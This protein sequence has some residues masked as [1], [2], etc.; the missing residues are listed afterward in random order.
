MTWQRQSPIVER[1]T[2][3]QL[4]R[5]LA[6]FCPNAVTD[7]RHRGDYDRDLAERVLVDATF[8]LM[9]IAWGESSLHVC[10][11]SQLPAG[12]TTLLRQW[13]DVPTIM[14]IVGGKRVRLVLIV[15]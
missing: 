6:Y 12:D 9:Q 10:R 1:S 13:V 7:L 4:W 2:G 11:S 3:C 15:P 5:I 14:A 8:F